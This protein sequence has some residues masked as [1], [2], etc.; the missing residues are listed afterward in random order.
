MGRRGTLCVVLALGA[1]LAGCGDDDEDSGG[2]G[3]GTATTGATPTT[4]PTTTETEPEKPD[5]AAAVPFERC[6]AEA[7]LE[8]KP[9]G[10]EY[11]DEKGKTK[12]REGLGIDN[13]TYLGFVQF[14]SKRVADV[15]EATDDGAAEEAEEVAGKFVEAFGFDPA[16]YVRR[17]GTTV[18]IFDDPPPS[19]DE[20]EQLT[21]CAGG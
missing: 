4:R 9:E 21:G 15:Y 2:G 12:G 17:E 13:A 11:T 1:L 10:T 20:V 14:P 6:L 3:G 7:G 5:G 16:E 18:L 8:L 19:E